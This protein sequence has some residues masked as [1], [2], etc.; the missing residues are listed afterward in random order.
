MS[1]ET[2]QCLY[3][4]ATRSCLGGASGIL[5]LMTW[6]ELDR[7]MG[8][9]ASVAMVVASLAALSVRSLPADYVKY[10]CESK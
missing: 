7:A 8:R 9:I 6:I 1:R 5:L 4:A 3:T 2:L 10:C